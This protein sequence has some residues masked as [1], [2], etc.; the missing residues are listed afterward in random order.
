MM[1]SMQLNDISKQGTSERMDMLLNSRD[2]EESTST[3]GT[4][5]IK[6]DLLLKDKALHNCGERV[7]KLTECSKSLPL[8]SSNN[9]IMLDSD[10]DVEVNI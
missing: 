2:P 3:K 1:V 10:D 9:V 4:S 8:A 5:M 6:L 7:N